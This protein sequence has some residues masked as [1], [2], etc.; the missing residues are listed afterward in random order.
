MVSV[1]VPSD[2]LLQHLPSYLGFSSL[3]LEIPVGYLFTAAPAK[4]SR[5]SLPWTRG[6]SSPFAAMQIGSSGKTQREKKKRFDTKMFCSDAKES[7]YNAGDP[8]LILGLGRSP[9]E[10]NG[11]PLQYSCLEN[12]MDGGAGRATV[13]GITKS[14]TRLCDC[15]TTPHPHLSS[16]K[17]GRKAFSNLGILKA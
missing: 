15:I 2:A 8:G 3:G 7:A 11:N 13:H 14:Q 9:G 12:P 1:C 4:G 16:K 5:C 10:G 6:I 17:A